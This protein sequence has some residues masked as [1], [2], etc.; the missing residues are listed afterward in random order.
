MNT[1]I[2][3]ILAMI[4]TIVVLITIGTSSVMA[5][6]TFTPNSM[7][8]P[9]NSAD[10]SDDEIAN[11]G[12]R[13][14]KAIQIVGVVLSVAIVAI[15]GIKYMMGSVEEKSEYKKSMIPYLVGAACIFLATTIANVVYTFL[16]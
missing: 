13:V 6:E 9:I 10:V 11:L 16:T 1:K 4:V 2:M 3:K 8:E 14:I 5:A 7:K 12:G 15:L